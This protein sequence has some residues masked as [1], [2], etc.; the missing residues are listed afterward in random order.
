[1]LKHFEA[2]NVQEPKNCGAS[3]AGALSIL[4]T[5]SQQIT[6]VSSVCSPPWVSLTTLPVFLE[7]SMDRELT[8][9]AS[10]LLI[11]PTSQVNVRLYTALARAS[12]AY[13]ACSR[14]S[15]LKSCRR[16]KDRR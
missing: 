2:V 6:W 8:L 13:A 5:A 4:G 7:S 16:G 10:D 14:F 9:E 1:M 3:P 11:F 12:L 15:G